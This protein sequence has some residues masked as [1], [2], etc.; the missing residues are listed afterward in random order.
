[1]SLPAGEYCVVA[2]TT[3]CK[4]VAPGPVASGAGGVRLL[5]AA[6]VLTPKCVAAFRELFRQL[7]EV[8]RGACGPGRRAVRASGLG[9]PRSRPTDAPPPP[10]A[11][12]PRG[13]PGS[14]LLLWH[15]AHVL[16]AV[17]PCG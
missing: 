14:L 16:A 8:R 5:N 11:I 10:R 3:G 2:C 12:E 4:L 9:E 7:D 6:G 1:V 17:P 15:R 13:K